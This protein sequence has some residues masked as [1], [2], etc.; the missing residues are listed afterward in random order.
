VAK[1]AKWLFIE[2]RQEGLLKLQ[3]QGEASGLSLGGRRRNEVLYGSQKSTGAKQNKNITLKIS[4]EQSDSGLLSLD[5]LTL[6]WGN[7]FCC[8][9]LIRLVFAPAKVALTSS[10][11]AN[12]R[13]QQA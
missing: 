12:L 1:N 7:Q 6:A 8:S 3:K 11:T 5:T 2:Q 9:L 13:N 10:S 4:S